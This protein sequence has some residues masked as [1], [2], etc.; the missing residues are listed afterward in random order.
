MQALCHFSGDPSLT[1]E[2]ARMTWKVAW[3]DVEELHNN[4]R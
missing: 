4:F 2:V 3:D 1:W